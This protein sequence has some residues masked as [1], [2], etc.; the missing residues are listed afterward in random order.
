MQLDGVSQLPPC[1]VCGKSLAVGEL[2]VETVIYAPGRVTDNLNG[3]YAIYQQ[4]ED[5][6]ELAR[7]SFTHAECVGQPVT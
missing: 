2:V 1:K 7:R 5:G 6:A 4:L 3:T